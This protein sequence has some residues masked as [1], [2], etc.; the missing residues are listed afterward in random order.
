MNRIDVISPNHEEAAS[1]VSTP[2]AEIEGDD[3]RKL[4]EK[5]VLNKFYS[6]A[7]LAKIENMPI[8]CI[9]SG[10]L[11]ALVAISQEKTTWVGAYHTS[12]Q[13]GKV[14][15]VTGAGNA[16]LGGFTAGLAMCSEK[17]PASSKAMPAW[18]L[19]EAQIA[20]Q[21]GSV[22]ASFVIEQQS[23]PEFHVSPHGFEMWNHEQAND[24]LS[25][26]QRR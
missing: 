11:G 8:I 7:S 24:R 15:D 17:K 26:L 23:L 6:E 22:S 21:M 14:V 19:K 9:R 13:A 5:L 1:F 10:A 2:K 18:T 12:Q 3:T 16:F 20:G 25:E 4:I